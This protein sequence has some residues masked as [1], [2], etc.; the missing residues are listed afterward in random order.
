MIR[1][2]H[3]SKIAAI[4]EAMNHRYLPLCRRDG[5]LAFSDG[6]NTV[7]VARED[8][9]RSSVWHLVPPPTDGRPHHD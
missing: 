6:R 3:G 8:R 5:V 2:N 7:A 1:R 9:A 4:R